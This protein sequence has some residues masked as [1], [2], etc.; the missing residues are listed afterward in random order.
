MN[1][2]FGSMS[3]YLLKELK[4]A[5]AGLLVR[6]VLVVTFEVLSADA[7]ALIQPLLDYCKTLGAHLDSRLLE[8]LPDIQPYSY[9]C[10]L[11]IHEGTVFFNEKELKTF[12]EIAHGLKAG[13]S[14]FA[15]NLG[16]NSHNKDITFIQKMSK[17]I[18]LLSARALL[19][20]RKHDIH[21]SCIIMLFRKS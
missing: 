18:N 10:A 5:L 4:S 12:T 21:E 3:E 19:S 15:V 9:D 1:T 16:E 14:L 6:K 8:T 20:M 13:A 2:N 17:W 7:H 11:I